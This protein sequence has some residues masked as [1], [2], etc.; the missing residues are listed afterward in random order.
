MRDVVVRVTFPG[1][2]AW[3]GWFGQLLATANRNL[4]L[5]RGEELSD[6]VPRLARFFAAESA[7]EIRDAVQALYDG[8]TPTIAPTSTLRAW[9][10]ETILTFR[11]HLRARA[12]YLRR[13]PEC[14]LWFLAF[15]KPEAREKKPCRRSQCRTAYANAEKDATR[16]R[17]ATHRETPG[18]RQGRR[19]RV[20]KKGT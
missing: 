1:R 19:S 13:C 2:F 14:E 9:T 6:D 11:A 15:T 7:S 20:P 12:F 18:F 16:R 8:R 17:V 4:R 5:E 10:W 3:E